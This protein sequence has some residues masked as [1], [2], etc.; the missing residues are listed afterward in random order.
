M[1]IERPGDVE[2][3]APRWFDLPLTDNPRK[4]SPQLFRLDAGLEQALDRGTLSP[5]LQAAF[6]EHEAA[7]SPTAAIVLSRPGD[8]WHVADPGNF[9]HYLIRKEHGRLNVYRQFRID[10]ARL[11]LK[12]GDQVRV[13]L[14][15]RDYRGEGA[16]G[17]AAVSDPVLL[18]VTDERGVLNAMVETDQRSAQ[19]LNAII[20]R[21]LGIGES[22]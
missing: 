19:Q 10:L 20:L 6:A 17:K 22:P 3:A 21:Q 1:L 14:E 18:T 8:R 15:A 9:Q 12:L 5:P 16:A 7:L 4:V 11:K 2:A 13:Q